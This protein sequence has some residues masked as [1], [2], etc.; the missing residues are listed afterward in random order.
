M[1]LS[2]KEIHRELKKADGNKA[3]SP[4]D[5]TFK[6]TQLFWSDIKRVLI[7]LFNQFFETANFDQCFLS[8]FISLNP[9]VSNTSSLNDPKLISF[10]VW[11]HKL[12][13]H[14]LATRLK[15]VIGKLVQNT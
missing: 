2:E 10:L 7:S 11:V 8:L 6:F 14:L 12:V 4:D 13:T 5:F 15:G 3:P 9:K 1:S